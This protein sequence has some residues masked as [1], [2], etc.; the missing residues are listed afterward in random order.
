VRANKKGV[1]KAIS[2]S[3][4]KVLAGG[5]ST[6]VGLYASSE[7]L[8]RVFEI[9]HATHVIKRVIRVLAETGGTGRT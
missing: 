7:K 2:V 3:F 1:A 4:A 5:L 8:L 6:P 9:N